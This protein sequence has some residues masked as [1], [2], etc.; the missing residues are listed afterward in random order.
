MNEAAQLAR[1]RDQLKAIAPGEWSRVHDSDGGCFVEATG[2]MGDL[3]EVARFHP[4]TDAAEIDFVVEAPR[5]MRFL[6]V[7]IDRAIAKL[8]PEPPRRNGPAGEPHTD[9]KNYAAEAGMK[10]Q[11]PRFLAYLEKQHGLE[12]PLTKEK[13]AQ[14]LRSLLGVSS[15]KNLNIDAQAAERW[16]ALRRDFDNWMRVAG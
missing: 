16:K 11:E 13:A 15:R 10:C 6:L 3:Y 14:K 12:R 9:P 4:G 5:N 1:I 8:R 2:A 7:L